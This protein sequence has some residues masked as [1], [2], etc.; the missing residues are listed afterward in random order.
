ME[1]NTLNIDYIYVYPDDIPI[2]PLTIH[3]VNAL[4]EDGDISIE[5]Y[6]KFVL[7]STYIP[8]LILDEE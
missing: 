6:N 7:D 2:E 3:I 1:N 5:E 8:K 4:L